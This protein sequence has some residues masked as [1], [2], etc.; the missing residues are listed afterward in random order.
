M[1]LD[2]GILRPHP[3]L[4]KMLAGGYIGGVAERLK[5]TDC[6]SVLIEYAGSN[7]APSTT[8]PLQVTVR[9]F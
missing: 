7:P 5:A 8:T 9:E 1:A 6:K 4:L 2:M 3:A